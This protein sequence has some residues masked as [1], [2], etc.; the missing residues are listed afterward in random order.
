MTSVRSQLQ[1]DQT[2]TGYNGTLRALDNVELIKPLL[3]GHRL[4]ATGPADESAVY[5]QLQDEARKRSGR[6][7]SSRAV[8]V[9]AALAALLV[10]LA[11][12]F[13]AFPTKHADLH[14]FGSIVQIGPYWHNFS[15]IDTWFPFGDSYTDMIFYEYGIQP[16]V[17]NPLGNP[18]LPDLAPR[19]GFGVTYVAYLAARYNHSVIKTYNMGRGGGTLDDEINPS[20]ILGC[21][22][23]ERYATEA[24]AYIA[25]ALQRRSDYKYWSFS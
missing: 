23:K 17:E 24:A 18:P 7:C 15:H 10:L 2:F 16:T 3:R 13:P 4:C 19:S 21:V 22:K 5:E 6:R 1:V 11:L 12:L 9:V 20:F 14:E 8:N 25:C